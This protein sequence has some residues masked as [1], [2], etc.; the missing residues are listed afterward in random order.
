MKEICGTNKSGVLKTHMPPSLFYHI[1]YIDG[2][3]P[4]LKQTD[5]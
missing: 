2:R 3:L 1:G 4:N 5:V